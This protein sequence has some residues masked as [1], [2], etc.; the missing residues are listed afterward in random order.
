MCHR[1]PIDLFNY[2]K[3]DDY[4]EKEQISILRYDDKSLYKINLYNNKWRFLAEN[5][6]REELVIHRAR[7]PEA[8]CVAYLRHLHTCR[9]DDVRQI[10]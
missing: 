10:G 2:D 9:E 6:L 5:L 8:T 1:N 4:Y 7:L 3:Y